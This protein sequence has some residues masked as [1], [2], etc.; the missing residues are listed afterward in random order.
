MDDLTG[1]TAVITGAA[2]GMGRSFA[3]RFAGAGMN[4]VLSDIEAPRLDEAVAE[5]SAHGT[6]VIGHVTDVAD[7][8]AV[9]ELADRAFGEFG[10]VHLL[11]NNAGDRSW[12]T[13]PTGSGCW[14]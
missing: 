1:K 8:G 2:S 12:S 3:N 10:G 13:P 11:C 4:I 5:V 9:D 7:G 6:G 14:G